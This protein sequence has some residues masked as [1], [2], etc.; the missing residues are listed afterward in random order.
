M[1]QLETFIESINVFYI[2]TLYT[3]IYYIQFMSILSFDFIYLFYIQ[4]D[5]YN[6]NKEIIFYSCRVQ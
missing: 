5:K 4:I 1:N 3:L 6:A 2:Y